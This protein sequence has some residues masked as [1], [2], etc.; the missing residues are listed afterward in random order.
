MKRVLMVAYHF[1]PEASSSGVL[2]TLKFGK[3]LPSFGWTPHILTLCESAYRVRDEQLLAQIPP[4]A[5]IHRVRGFD[6]TRHLAIQGRYPAALT[7]PDRFVSW[8]P[9]GAAKGL[10]VIRSMGIHALY[11]TSPLPTAHLIAA[12]LRTRTGIPW[13][14]DF[15]DP[16]IEEGLYPRPGSLRNWVERR[17]ERIVISQADRIT[18]TTPLFREELAR[19]YPQLPPEKIRVVFNGYDEEDFEGIKATPRTD[20]FEILHAGLVTPDYRDPRPL[21]DAVASL[22]GG[23][24]LP[25]DDV[26]VAFLGGGPYLDAPA[27]RQVLQQRGLDRVVDV[28][29]RVSYEESLVRMGQASVLLLLQASDDTRSLIPAKAFEYLRAGRPLLALTSDGMTAELLRT[30][31]RGIV[32]PPGNSESIARVLLDLYAQHRDTD[33]HDTVADPGKVDISR[34]ERRFLTGELAHLLDEVIGAE[35]VAATP[36]GRVQMA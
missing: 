4:T 20:R 24:H 36:S 35:D 29:G 16:W 23:G 2:R 10:G 28:T 27:F 3:Y 12:V 19:R 33:R 31:G 14:A 32:V 9:F 25:A 18:V 11:S 17:L 1:P 8:L 13:I 26:R 21:L 30:T 5:V 34:Y 22:I 15:R 6:A 7:V